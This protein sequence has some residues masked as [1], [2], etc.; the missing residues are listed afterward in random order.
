MTNDDVKGIVPER[1]RDAFSKINEWVKR[2]TEW[3]SKCINLIASENIV[4]PDV[5]AA[6]IS[7]FGGRYAEGRPG[8]RF[9]QG[10]WML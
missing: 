9:Y 1:P 4:S 2:S 6:L 8:K 10:T 5:R 7:D 3:R